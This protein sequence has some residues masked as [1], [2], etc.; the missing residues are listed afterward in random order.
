MDERGRRLDQRVGEAE[1]RHRPR[2]RITLLLCMAI[3]TTSSMRG[4]KSRAVRIAQR[5]GSLGLSHFRQTRGTHIRVFQVRDLVQIMGEIAVLFEIERLR[6]W[7]PVTQPGRSKA[8][9]GSFSL[10]AHRIPASFRVRAR[11]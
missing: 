9:T 8:P 7:Q 11:H 6:R 5:E 1:L 3:E 2:L 10:P 4:P